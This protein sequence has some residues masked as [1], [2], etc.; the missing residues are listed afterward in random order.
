MDTKILHL[1]QLSNGTTASCTRDGGVQERH[2]FDPLIM[3][4]LKGLPIVES[5]K[6]R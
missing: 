3:S 2:D 6:Y 5:Y 4:R 1:G